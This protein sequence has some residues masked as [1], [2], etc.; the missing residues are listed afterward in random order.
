MAG[1]SKLKVYGGQAVI[2]TDRDQLA[3]ALEDYFQADNRMF[4]LAWQVKDDQLWLTR[5]EHAPSDWEHS[6]F[7]NGPGA[8]ATR[9]MRWLKSY[10]T[11]SWKLVYLRGDFEGLRLEPLK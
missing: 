10:R 6:S 1:D 3:T 11:T 2:G 9:G 8:F 5:R 4:H 7:L